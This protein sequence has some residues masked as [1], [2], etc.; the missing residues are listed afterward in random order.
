M[1]WILLF[2]ALWSV[3][4][5]K[6]EAKRPQKS[7]LDQLIPPEVK[8]DAFYDAIY[9]LARSESVANIFEIGSSS[10]EGSTEAFVRGIRENAAHPKLFCMEVSRCRFEKLREHYR[11]EPSVHCYNVSSIPLEKFP[12]EQEVAQFYTT[13]PSRLRETPLPTVLRWLRQDIAYLQREAGVPQN[14][15][16]RI[17]Q[18]NGIRDFDMVLIDGSEFTGQA[19]LMEVYG[20]RLILLDDTC[21]FK[22][23]A[24][25][26]RLLHDPTYELIEESQTVRNGYAIFK[27]RM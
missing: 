27:R 10:G 20:A 14:G 12:S 8:N 6:P 21:T 5:S 7:Q 19:E 18:E 11:D 3:S 25:R 16:E 17:R 22:N 9:R 23:W 2:L 4:C 13:V 15:I 24:N 1:K 26:E